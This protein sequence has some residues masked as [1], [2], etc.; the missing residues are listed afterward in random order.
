MGEDGGI[1]FLLLW[2]ERITYTFWGH[3]L[4][5][6]PSGTKVLRLVERST[7]SGDEAIAEA[8]FEI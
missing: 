5:I 4:C 8:A 1:V 2:S 7:W 6:I 3:K